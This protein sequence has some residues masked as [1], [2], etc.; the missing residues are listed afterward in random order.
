MREP[1]EAGKD[2]MARNEK[3]RLPWQLERAFAGL[4]KQF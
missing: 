3:A 4:G 2:F 1:S